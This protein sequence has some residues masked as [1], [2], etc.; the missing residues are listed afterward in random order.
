MVCVFWGLGILCF[1]CRVDRFCIWGWFAGV[2]AIRKLV[3]LGVG[4]DLDVL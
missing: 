3:Y 4:F 2:D 1:Y